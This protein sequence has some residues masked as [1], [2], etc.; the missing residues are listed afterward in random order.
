[1]VVPGIV[2]NADQDVVLLVEDLVKS[3]ISGT[4]LILVTLPM[5]GL[6]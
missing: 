3:Y 2:Q 6:F 5:S 4:S 1:M